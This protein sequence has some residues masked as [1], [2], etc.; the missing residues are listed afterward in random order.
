MK[1]IL[2]LVRIAALYE[3]YFYLKNKKEDFFLLKLFCL[4][5]LC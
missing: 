3:S 4:K 5:N 1:V 2:L